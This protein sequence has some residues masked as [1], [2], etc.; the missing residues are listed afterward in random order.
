MLEPGKF[1]WHI[2]P[3]ASQAE[4]IAHYADPGTNFSVVTHQAFRD[5]LI[6]LGAK[7]AGLTEQQ[8]ADKLN[9]M[10]AP[11]R[12]AWAAETMKGAGMDHDMLMVDEGHNLLNR[13]G[14]ENSLLA[15]VVD[16]VSENTPYYVNSTAD[17]IKNDLSEA[18][19]TLRKM[20]PARY[21]D[22]ESFMRRYGIDTEASKDALRREM[23]RYLYADHIKPGIQVHSS[24]Q[25]VPLSHG[26]QQAID[27]IEANIAKL[28]ISRL[29]GE[30]DVKAARALSPDSF[31]G[32]PEEAHAGIAQHLAR[33]VGVLRQTALA[34]AIDAHPES[35]KLEAIARYAHA[36]QG[37]PGVI[38]ARSL[39]A[40]E[41]I[42]K[43]LT[44]EGHRVV[45]ITGRD[46][47]KQKSAKRL[48]FRPDVGEPEA[49][50]LVAS[51]A[52]AVGL[53]AQRGAWLVQNDTP[54]TAMT[55]NQ[56][57]GRIN[58]LGQLN[59]E[60]ELTDMVANHPHE[61]EARRR[62]NQKYGLRDIVT[63]PLEKLDDRGFAPYLRAARAAQEQ[64]GAR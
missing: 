52:G 45:T 17:T 41:N 3:G 60:I 13:A 11:E 1:K 61:R 59:P 35:S 20:D 22:R 49:D 55:H 9:A 2:A 10:P 4:R 48:K 47:A 14:K 6:H 44:K 42:A 51:D 30:A 31:E 40:V 29:G 25:Q 16:A 27:E 54:L 37:K 62:L 53:N 32:Q 34:R 28:R 39:D 26:Q 33:S 5:D 50:I 36:R 38:F 57:R 21:R 24:E 56:R 58:R 7:A 19:D 46:T 15:N 64:D 43:R 8:M 63:S 18:H 23:A 12:K